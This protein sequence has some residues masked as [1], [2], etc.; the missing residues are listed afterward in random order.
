MIS[1]VRK[2]SSRMFHKVD[3]T[4]RYSPAHR[5]RQSFPRAFRARLC[6]SETKREHKV[7][8][9]VGTGRSRVLCLVRLPRQISIGSE[10][11]GK[12][13]SSM[14][15]VAIAT[16]RRYTVAITSR[17]NLQTGHHNRVNLP[18]RLTTTPRMLDNSDTQGNQTA[19]FWRNEFGRSLANVRYAAGSCCENPP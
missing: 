2:P 17:P 4:L 15:G 16:P 3:A 11:Y 9:E 18:A 10:L 1:L 19:F 7:H 6:E 13:P 14:S 5:G 12:P 8:Q